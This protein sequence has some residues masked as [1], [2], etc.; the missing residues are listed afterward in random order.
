MGQLLE[1]IGE[2][3][4]SG[5]YEAG[6]R[7]LCYGW[8]DHPSDYAVAHVIDYAVE[9]GNA[10]VLFKTLS[11]PVFRRLKRERSGVNGLVADLRK[12]LAF[13]SQTRFDLLR[14][15]QMLFLERW[16]SAADSTP[17]DVHQAH[18]H[19]FTEF[20]QLD[21]PIDQRRN[22]G[23][24][25]VLGALL[26]LT[27]KPRKK[28]GEPRPRSHHRPTR[29]I[30]AG[31]LAVPVWRLS[32]ALPAL[33][34]CLP[35]RVLRGSGP[36]AFGTNPCTA[37]G[38]PPVY[39]ICP[40]CGTR[41][42]LDP[43]WMMSEGQVHPILLRA[44]LRLKLKF[45]GSDGLIRGHDLH[46][47]DFPLMLGLRED[48]NGIAFD[49][50]D[51]FWLNTGGD[52]I[53][54]RFQR[55]GA[56][57]QLVGLVDHVTYD[58]R[59]GVLDS[60]EAILQQTLQRQGK[61]AL[62]V[63]LASLLND[64]RGGSVRAAGAFTSDFETKLAS[65]KH[66]V[67]RPFPEKVGL[68]DLV[69]LSRECRVAASPVLR[70][71]MALVRRDPDEPGIFSAPYIMNYDVTLLKTG[72]GRDRLT[73]TP[74]NKVHPHLGDDGIVRVGTMVEPGDVLVGILGPWLPGEAGSPEVRRRTESSPE[75]KLL[76]AIFGGPDEDLENLENLTDRSFTYQGNVPAQVIAVRVLV[77]KAWKDT[78][79]RSD[80][81]RSIE[82]DEGGRFTGERTGLRHSHT[83]V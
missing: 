10:D 21:V 48:R 81:G 38:H 63:G 31:H 59:S 22:V 14:Y 62:D 42:T 20:L 27:I 54:K 28:R 47:M 3:L 8:C 4:R 35:L 43:I 80:P 24:H 76:R 78:E 68:L 15:V 19:E 40:Q 30:R 41:V 53:G 11:D 25:W 73:P 55:S 7:A 50:P 66:Q 39:S 77:G 18:C 82:R 79:V 44:P 17:L 46:L 58:G 56:S 72:A 34:P 61:G 49:L 2:G 6:L 67:T 36:L 33:R 52:L 64:P 45:E 65:W 69:G 23:I 1:E 75:L 9:E 29:R 51:L 70:H 71:G 5:R 12:G 32:G 83:G 57:V 60:L 37:C 26:P 13:F 74:G 16:S